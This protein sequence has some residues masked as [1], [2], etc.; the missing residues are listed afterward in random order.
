MN[1]D[2]PFWGVLWFMFYL[3]EIFKTGNWGV[4]GCIYGQYIMGGKK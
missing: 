2:T 1:C 4:T 3:S